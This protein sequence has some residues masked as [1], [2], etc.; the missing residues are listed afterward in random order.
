[1]RLL[2]PFAGYSKANGIH[3]FH[4]ALFAGSYSVNIFEKLQE[5]EAS[6]GEEHHL[7]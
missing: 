5:G 7:E 1:M 4:L 3:V 6:D 2:D